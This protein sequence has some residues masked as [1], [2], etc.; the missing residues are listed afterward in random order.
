MS[1]SLE[2]RILIGN[3]NLYIPSKEVSIIEAYEN[4]L[5]FLY[6][7][8]YSIYYPDLYG[9]GEIGITRDDDNGLIFDACN[10]DKLERMYIM[11]SDSKGRFL[12]FYYS[13]NLKNQHTLI[14]NCVLSGE[15]KKIEQFVGESYFFHEQLYKQV[16]IIQDE[17]QRIRL[18]SKGNPI[19]IH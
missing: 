8:N 11:T 19:T 1:E 13:K 3:F 5:Q 4:F 7:K 9:Y 12:N 2:N 14:L 6:A 15:Q 10:S 17:G 18:D 16:D